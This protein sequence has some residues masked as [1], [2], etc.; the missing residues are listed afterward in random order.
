MIK[1][2]SLR[3]VIQGGGTKAITKVLLHGWGCSTVIEQLPSRCKAMFPMTNTIKTRQSGLDM[4]E[5]DWP[6]RGR[7]EKMKTDAEAGWMMCNAASHCCAEDG[8]RG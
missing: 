7:E 3:W 5:E 8:D 2:K 4:K 1:L 6:I